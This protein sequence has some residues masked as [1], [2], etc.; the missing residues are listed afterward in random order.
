MRLSKLE[1]DRIREEWNDAYMWHCATEHPRAETVC[2]R[3]IHPRER[4]A[5]DQGSSSNS[6]SKVPVIVKER[7]RLMDRTLPHLP[8]SNYTPKVHCVH[9]VGIMR[10]LIKHKAAG[11][12]VRLR[13]V[14]Y[15]HQRLTGQNWWRTKFCS[16]ASVWQVY[17]MPLSSVP[18]SNEVNCATLF[19]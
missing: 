10:P 11:I 16:N 13:H 6:S 7:M 4:R 9:H 2:N 8:H 17:S 14:A 5:K 18:C 12:S 1:K 3:A 15:S 19:Y